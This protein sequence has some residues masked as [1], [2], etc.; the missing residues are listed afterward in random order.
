MLEEA[1]AAGHAVSALTL[2][3]RYDA[4][5]VERVVGS[6]RSGKLLTDT[7]KATFVFV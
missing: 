6:A 5:A 1:S 2:F 4:P 3:T 7:T